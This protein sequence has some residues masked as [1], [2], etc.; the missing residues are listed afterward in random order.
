MQRFWFNSWVRK[1]HWRND[2]L[3]TPVFWGFPCGSAGKESACNVGDL[4]LIPGL[5][6][7]PGEGKGYPLQYS[8]LENCTISFRSY[9]PKF[10][11]TATPI[12]KGAWEIK[13][14]SGQC[15]PEIWDLQKIGFG[16]ASH[17]WGYFV[18]AYLIFRQKSVTLGYPAQSLTTS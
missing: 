18:A 10:S 2:R 15:L 7:H 4:G 12:T 3:P 16:T 1:I 8:G 13:Y 14:L 17:R 11:C 5:G 6:R 9:W